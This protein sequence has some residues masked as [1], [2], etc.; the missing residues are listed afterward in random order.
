MGMIASLL[1]LVSVGLCVWLCAWWSKHVPPVHI[2]EEA[3]S[4]NAPAA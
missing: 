3:K 4:V 2:H 1:F